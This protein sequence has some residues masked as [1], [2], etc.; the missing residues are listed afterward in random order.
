[1]HIRTRVALLTVLILLTAC[2]AEKPVDTSTGTSIGGTKLEPGFNLMSPKQDIEIGKKSAE[3][4]EQQLPLVDDTA[5]TSYVSKIGAKL[6]ANAPG[7]KFPYEFHVVNASDLNAFAL[8]GGIIFLNRGVLE[9]AKSE[10]EV[11]GVLAHE[12]SHVA[13]RHGTHQVSKAYVTQAGIGIL[14]GVLGGHV[15]RG[16]ASIINVLGGFGLNSLFLKNSR[17]AESEADVEGVQILARSGYDPNDMVHFFETLEKV[18]KR[19]TVNWLSDHPA[20]ER[21]LQ[22]IEQEAKLVKSSPEPAGNSG[23]IAVQARFHQ[24]PAAQ[25]FSAMTENRDTSGEGRR[26]GSIPVVHVDPP[27]PSL[28][29]YTSRSGAYAIDYPSNWRVY[30]DEHTGV[31][32]APPGGAG[33]VNGAT[34]VVYGAIVNRYRPMNEETQKRKMEQGAITVREAADDLVA[35]VRQTSPYLQPVEKQSVDGGVVLRLRGKDP[36][37]GI[38]EEVRAVVKEGPGRFLCLLAIVGG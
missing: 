15:G 29:T 19:R 24:L 27:S 16:T 2:R 31:T 23:L 37:T 38:D 35:Q 20:P 32:F 25:T 26:G 33:D 10:G 8:P 36:A 30:E 3:Q 34:E 13:L 17:T 22:R 21:R 14:G 28:Q 18:D 9:A 1:M 11:A 6:A 5:V 7:Y 4:V 12:I